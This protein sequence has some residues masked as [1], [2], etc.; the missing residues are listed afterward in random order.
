MA[1]FSADKKSSELAPALQASLWLLLLLLLLLLARHSQN[2][3]ANCSAGHAMSLIEPPLGPYKAR[4]VLLE[5]A[6]PI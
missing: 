3:R 1:E 6:D 2:Q 4:A 5:P